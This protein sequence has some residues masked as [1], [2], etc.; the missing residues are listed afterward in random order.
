MKA[1]RYLFRFQFSLCC[2]YMLLSGYAL[3]ATQIGRVAILVGE[4]VVVSADGAN[5]K[6]KNKAPIYQNDTIRTHTGS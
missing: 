3:A 4:A 5:R 2:I 1:L 6:L